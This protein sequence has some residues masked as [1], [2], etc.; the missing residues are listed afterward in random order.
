MIDGC[1]PKDWVHFQVNKWISFGLIVV[2]FGVAYLYARRQGPVTGRLRRRGHGAAERAVGWRGVSVPTR[3]F[4]A[5]DPAR[6][7]GMV[8]VTTSASMSRKSGWS[9]TVL[10]TREA[11]A[12]LAGHGRRL[13][14]EVVQHLD[15]V[16]KEADRRN[17]GRADH[18]RRAFRAGYSQTSG[19]R[20]GSS[21]LPLRLW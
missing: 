3:R 4:A 1:T 13:C 14:V 9:P 6:S 16:D 2:I 12:Y 8:S 15:V 10:R 20:P 19:P 7:A 21:G 18:R 5:P 11:E 17:Y